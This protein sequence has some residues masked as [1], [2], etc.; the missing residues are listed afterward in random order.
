MKATAQLYMGSGAAQNT[1]V[2]S[3]LLISVLNC[4]CKRLPGYC[5]QGGCQALVHFIDAM[6]A[7]HTRS[8]VEVGAT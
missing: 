6:A 4:A 1:P 7:R 3:Q 5:P 2:R 8:N